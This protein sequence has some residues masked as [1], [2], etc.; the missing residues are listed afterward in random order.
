M[1]ELVTAADDLLSTI[2]SDGAN[3]YLRHAVMEFRQA[4]DAAREPSD[5]TNAGRALSRFCTD[6]LDWDTDLYRRCMLLV[7]PTQVR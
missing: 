2:P 3:A 6:T 1:Q 5:A 7:K 4:V